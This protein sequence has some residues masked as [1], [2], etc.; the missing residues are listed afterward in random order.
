MHEGERERDKH[1]HTDDSKQDEPINRSGGRSIFSA[2]HDKALQHFREDPLKK[3]DVK[4]PAF[5]QLARN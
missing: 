3:S 4:C 5:V 1:A 2:R